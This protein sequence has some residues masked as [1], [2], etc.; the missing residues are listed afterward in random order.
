MTASSKSEAEGRRFSLG[1]I[2]SRDPSCEQPYGSQSERP[3]LAGA[4]VS[5]VL[6]FE[7]S[8]VRRVNW[9]PSSVS[10]SLTSFPVTRNGTW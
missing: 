2:C 8:N 10:V 1:A 6:L 3:L 9:G 7:E 4:I 5:R